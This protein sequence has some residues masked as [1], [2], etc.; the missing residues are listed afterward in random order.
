MSHVNLLPWREELRQRQKK[1]FLTLLFAV[2][3]FVMIIVYLVGMLI[4]SKIAS[5]NQR[6]AFLQGQIAVLD[7]EIAK[8]KD[9]KDSK[10]AI[11][12]RMALIEQLQTSRNVAPIVFDELA[13]L[14]P[15]G[16][17][18]RSFSRQGNT[19]E[20]SGVSESNNRLS[21]FM[22]K[23][24]DS[25]IFGQGE[26]SSIVADTSAPDAV[27]EFKLTFTINSSVAP[28]FSETPAEGQK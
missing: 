10:K 4:D 25:K 14:V 24:E 13:R 1:D 5:Q 21:S 17:S 22:R 27:S 11:E 8:I 7:A 15:P 2:A 19:V 3:L 28:D 16:V 6:N 18:F 12:Q 20:L 9:I 26:L 23:I